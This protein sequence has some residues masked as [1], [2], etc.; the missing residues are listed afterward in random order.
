MV[1][2]CCHNHSLSMSQQPGLGSRMKESAE[3]TSEQAKK[4]GAETGQFAKEQA[5]V[6][7]QHVQ[8][9]AEQ[10]QSKLEHGA[11]QVKESATGTAQQAKE[12]AQRA[13]EKVSEGAS[14][15][16]QQVKETAEHAGETISGTTQQ[17]GEKLDTGVSG[18]MKNIGMNIRCSCPSC[19]QPS[20][21]PPN[22]NVI[23]PH[24]RSVFQAASTGER[25][26]EMAKELKETI[27]EALPSQV[28]GRG[29]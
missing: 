24:C 20:S 17:V 25:I 13:G 27:L 2:L 14:K 8:A 15:A 22:M 1:G 10:A 7:A 12:S 19:G 29:G 6:G 28:T 9:G 26:S 21:C 16:G 3:H 11:G 18:A 4:G 5:Q 23:C